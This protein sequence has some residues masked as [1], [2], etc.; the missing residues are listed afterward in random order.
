[1]LERKTIR[2]AARE[3][4]ICTATAFVWRHKYLDA[5]QTMMEEVKMDGVVEADEAFF[6]CPSKATTSGAN[7]S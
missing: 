3:C 4:G 1:M 6:A 5:L 2:E 7:S